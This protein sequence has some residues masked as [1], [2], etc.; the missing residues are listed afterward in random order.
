MYLA[1]QQSDRNQEQSD[2]C[3]A[4][5]CVYNGTTFTDPKTTHIKTD[6]NVPIISVYSL[7]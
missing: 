7:L 2:D 6:I 5:E 1:A 4:E 3:Q